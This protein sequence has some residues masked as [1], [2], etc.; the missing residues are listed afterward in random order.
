MD[1]EYS[2]LFLTYEHLDKRSFR[3]TDV[4]QFSSRDSRGRHYAIANF[5][6]TSYLFSHENFLKDFGVY[7]L[8]LTILMAS[9]F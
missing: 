4:I 7:L 6:C 8:F 1:S 9:R 2:L 3:H 5:L